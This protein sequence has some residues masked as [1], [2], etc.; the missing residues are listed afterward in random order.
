MGID[1]AGGIWHDAELSGRVRYHCF[2]Y[3]VWCLRI[4][5]VA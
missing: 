1:E 5:L 3:R 2:V 4:A